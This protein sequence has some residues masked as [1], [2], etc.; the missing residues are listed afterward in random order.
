MALEEIDLSGMTS[1]LPD[2]AKKVIEEANSRIDELF[3]TEK[4]RKYPKYLPS[5]PEPFFLA[6]DFLTREEMPLGN[7]FC[8]WGSGFGVH[9]CLAAALGYES[10]GIEIESELV[11]LAS[12]LAADLNLEVE[13]LQTSYVPEGFES[14]T[15]IGGEE[16]VLP[17]EF[18]IPDHGGEFEPSYEGM[19][20]PTS[21]IDVIFVYPH[22]SDQEFMHQLFDAIACEGAILIAYYAQGD[23]HAFR[24]VFEDD[25][26]EN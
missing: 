21:E 2:S 19:P 23:I 6:L 5:D 12:R 13:F 15:G 26:F 16:L 7:V 8:E 3:E 24:K 18:T 17:D 10:Y 11:D 25:E 14:Y 9:A 22:P 4:N 1:R 20:H